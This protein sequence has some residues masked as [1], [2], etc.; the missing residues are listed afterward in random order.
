MHCLRRQHLQDQQV[1][2]S[3]QYV[4]RSALHVA[5]LSFG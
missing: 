5:L 1:E 4:C 2:R 3:L